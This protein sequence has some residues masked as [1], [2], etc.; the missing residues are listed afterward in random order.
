M[1]II[2]Y[3]LLFV[4]LL[5]G[6][7]F[8]FIKVVDKPLPDGIAGPDAEQMAKEMLISVNDSAWNNTGAVTWRFVRSPSDHKYI[9]DKTSHL[10]Q[11]EFNKNIVQIDINN[12][13]G[14]VLGNTSSLST[15]DKA[16][17]CEKAWKMWSNDSFWLN[18]IT[19]IFDPG[20]ERSLATLDNG[21]TGLKVT[22]VSGGVT[23][24]DSY[25][26]T[27]ND[28][29][30]PER[31]NFWVSIIPVGGLG[32]TWDNWVKL[33]TGAWVSTLHEGVITINIAD[34]RG[35]QTLEELT[36]NSELFR[37]LLE[38]S[39]KELMSY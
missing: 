9:W 24:G 35:K 28:S 22:Y 17:L 36:G 30:R 37:P 25:V 18:P 3:L 8:V 23:P 4:L 6:G 10:A 29:Y 38:G 21:Q 14:V 2:K 7:V 12:R 33:S 13:R 26:W 27:L 19:K 31:W 39:A 5:I 11:V 16:E 20:T 34:V 32:F 15:L 1:K